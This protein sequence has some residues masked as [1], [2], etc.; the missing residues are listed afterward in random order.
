MFSL[1][2]YKSNRLPNGYKFWAF[3]LLMVG[4]FDLFYISCR[5][6][7]RKGV[8]YL[9]VKLFGFELILADC[10]F[11]VGFCGSDVFMRLK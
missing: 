2:T 1:L 8:V 5:R 10:G 6:S 7:N 4:S 9:C 11:G 3:G